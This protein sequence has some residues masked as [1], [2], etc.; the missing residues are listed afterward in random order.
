MV[1]LRTLGRTRINDSI[2][3]NHGKQAG[4]IVRV[5]RRQNT[6]NHLLVAIQCT[7]DAK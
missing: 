3:E 4:A 2:A 6:D 7:T 5:K 1:Y